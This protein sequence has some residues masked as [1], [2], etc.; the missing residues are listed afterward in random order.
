MIENQT[1]SY[2]SFSNNVTRLFMNKYNPEFDVV[3]C[4]VCCIA[5]T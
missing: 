4:Y 1:H 5:Y 3:D 2:I